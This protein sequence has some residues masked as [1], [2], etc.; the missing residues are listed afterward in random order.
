MSL[1][2]ADEDIS[3]GGDYAVQYCTRDACG[4][5]GWCGSVR[6]GNGDPC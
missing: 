6:G 4:A 2:R 1:F 5:R 3:L